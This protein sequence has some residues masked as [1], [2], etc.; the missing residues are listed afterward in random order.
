M[1]ANIKKTQYFY[2]MKYDHI[3]KYDFN[4]Q[5]KSHKEILCSKLIFL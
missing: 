3:I 4:G 1:N 5:K 2:Q